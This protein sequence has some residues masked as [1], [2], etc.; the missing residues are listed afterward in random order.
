MGWLHHEHAQSDQN[1]TMEPHS[2]TD[3][4]ATER[5]A[6]WH[7]PHPYQPE[8]RYMDFAI[9]PW[10]Y[11]TWDGLEGI[12]TGNVLWASESGGL[13]DPSEVVRAADSLLHTWEASLDNL[14]PDAPS[15]EVDRWLRDMTATVTEQRFF[16]VSACFDG[17]K[18]QH[19]KSYAG[20]RGYAIELDRDAE[21]RLLGPA[22]T[23]HRPGFTPY[24]WWRAVTYGDYD[25]GHSARGGSL[26]HGSDGIVEYLLDEFAAK[27]RGLR[28]DE[29]AFGE[30]L[31]AAY[32][33]SVCFNKHS[34]YSEEEETR[35]AFIEPPS[36]GFV[37]HRDGGFSPSGRTSYLKV[38]ADQSDLHAYSVTRAQPLPI[39]SVRIGPRYGT[40]VS[41]EIAAVTA[42]L[43]D[44]GYPEVS[45]DASS[46]PYRG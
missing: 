35:L 11:T 34:A 6:R 10:H 3:A 41:S 5:T 2:R 24:P 36:E 23:L 1:Q 44:N 20:G 22:P 29:V 43:R 32:L 28:P 38:T 27:S 39:R 21:Y 25:T 19:W 42:L 40:E 16:F 37:H 45:V 8:R 9:N 14:I 15:D 7:E 4:R 12:I 46:I 33:S 30:H 31:E 18:L 17:D 13:N 26:F